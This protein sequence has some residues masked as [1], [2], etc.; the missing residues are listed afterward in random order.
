MKRREFTLHEQHE[1]NSY[2]EEI[3]VAGHKI[4]NKALGEWANA[5]FNNSASALTIGRLL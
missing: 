2:Q 3:F 1:I 4:S 5:K